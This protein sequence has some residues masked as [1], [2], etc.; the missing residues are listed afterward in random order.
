MEL[1][2]F[3]L[4]MIFGFMFFGMHQDAK[5]YN[6][7]LP[8]PKC[9]EIDEIHDWSRHPVTDK[10]TCCKCNYEAGSE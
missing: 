5:R 4:M 3:M 9:H 10:L 8:K 7:Q 6:S 2:I 1:L